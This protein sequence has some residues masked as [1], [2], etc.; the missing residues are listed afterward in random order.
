MMAEARK[1]DS[2]SHDGAAPG[3]AAGHGSP[4]RPGQGSRPKRRLPATPTSGRVRLLQSQ[5]NVP[6][7]KEAK[8]PSR[9]SSGIFRASAV[10]ASP[11]AHARTAH[12]AAVSPAASG[13]KAQPQPQSRRQQ[14]QQKPT[15]DRHHQQPTPKVKVSEDGAVRQQPDPGRSRRPML[16]RAQP[17]IDCD[18]DAGNLSSLFIAPPPQFADPVGHLALPSPRTASSGYHTAADR[19]TQ[20]PPVTDDAHMQAP[21]PPRSLSPRLSVKDI[22]KVPPPESSSLPTSPSN[23]T[24]EHDHEARHEEAP[25]HGFHHDYSD[26]EEREELLHHLKRQQMHSDASLSLADAVND[27]V[28]RQTTDVPIDDAEGTARKHWIGTIWSVESKLGTNIVRRTIRRPNKYVELGA[29][30]PSRKGEEPQQP[31]D[32]SSSVCRQDLPVQYHGEAHHMSSVLRKQISEELHVPLAA[33]PV[34]QASAPVIPHP[35]PGPHGHRHQTIPGGPRIAR[36]NAVRKK[37]N[38]HGRRRLSSASTT[39]GSTDEQESFADQR[40]P[41]LTSLVTTHKHRDSI[42]RL[43]QA[44]DMRG[45]RKQQQTQPSSY[46]LQGIAARPT[47]REVRESLKLKLD[48]IVDPRLDALAKADLGADGSLDAVRG[49]YQGLVRTC[50]GT[51]DLQTIADDMVQN[52]FSEREVLIALSGITVQDGGHVSFEEF[53]GMCIRVLRGRCH[54]FRPTTATTDSEA[55][56]MPNRAREKE[57]TKLMTAA[58]MHVEVAPEEEVFAGDVTGEDM[59]DFIDDALLEGLQITFV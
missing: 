25:A 37:H 30:V 6:E 46:V 22:P 57:R 16:L 17:S 53:E 45:V 26:D 19:R 34:R 38:H 40:T 10:T 56:V 36:T 48:G 27:E 50:R 15:H 24:A 52:G 31:K 14:Q 28:L 12:T 51:L 54:A 39:G 42:R 18:D 44:L 3:L 43:E 49:K 35:V 9:R 11:P 21:Q 58:H 33:R 20:P 23:D 1:D 32:H 7:T 29:R 41:S 4:Q 47:L 55:A 13:R 5:K 59:D 8:S 2:S